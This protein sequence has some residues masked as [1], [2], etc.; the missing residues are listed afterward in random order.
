[1]THRFKYDVAACNLI[2][3]YSIM[4]RTYTVLL[5]LLRMEEM[6]NRKYEKTNPKY[7][8][9]MTLPRRRPYGDQFNTRLR[10]L[11]Q[12]KKSIVAS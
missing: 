11:P 8:N 4:Y 9:R 3:Y 1:M 5:L 2:V 7:I 6:Q 12:D 10:I